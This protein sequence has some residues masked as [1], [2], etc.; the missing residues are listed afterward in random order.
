M[1]EVFQAQ[2]VIDPMSFQTMMTEEDYKNHIK[3]QL[4][5]ALAEK[6]METNRA[7]FTYIKN[8][9]DYTTTVIGRVKL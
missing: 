8:P 4:T 1:S 5:Y 9:N 6:I 3:K 2:M 7:S